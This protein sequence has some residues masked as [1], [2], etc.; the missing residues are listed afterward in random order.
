M[1]NIYEGKQLFKKPLG[2]HISPTSILQAF[3]SDPNNLPYIHYTYIYT[4]ICYNDN[5][6]CDS[7]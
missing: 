1:F 3:N 7:C 4:Y 5:F 2:G 6:I